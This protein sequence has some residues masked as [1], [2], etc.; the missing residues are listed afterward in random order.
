MEI[1]NINDHLTCSYYDKSKRPLIEK[2]SL[3]KGEIFK[4]NL[5][6]SKIIFVKVGSIQ[7]SYQKVNDI[8]VNAGKFILLPPVCHLFAEVEEDVEFVIFRINSTMQ[9]CQTFSIGNLYDKNYEKRN[10]VAVLDI[11]ERIDAF[12]DLTS[13]AIGDGLKCTKFYNIKIEELLYYLRIYYPTKDLTDFFSPILSGD[14]AFANFVFQ[15]YRK[16]KTAQ[17]FSDLYGYSQSSF[18]KQFKK[19]FG[20][21]VYQWMINQRGKEIYHKLVCSDKGLTEIADEYNFS[22]ASQ[23]CDF[24]K[25]HLGA[26]P[27]KIRR[28][29]KG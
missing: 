23:F 8:T 2:V 29:K 16:V 12:L 18:E 28:S 24:C 19:V 17:E 14:S 9:L 13:K 11:N 21:S 26:S 22:S 3:G 1:T 27:S 4:R 10:E 5:I 6:D 15:N 7:I 25:Q 20:T